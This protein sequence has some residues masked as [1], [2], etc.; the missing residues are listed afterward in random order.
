[1]PTQSSAAYPSYKTAAANGTT[2]AVYSNYPAGAASAH[3]PYGVPPVSHMPRAGTIGPPS[4]PS[5]Y[6]TSPATAAGVPSRRPD[7]YS[8]PSVPPSMHYVPHQPQTMPY[9]WVN[10]RFESNWI[11]FST[12]VIFYRS[13]LMFDLYH[14]FCFHV[15]FNVSTTKKKKLNYRNIGVHV[16]FQCVQCIIFMS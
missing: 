11:F 13:F 14:F 10:I 12:F 8:A 2:S 7:Y 6:G 9:R 16:P 3:T 4:V 5:L 1:M 15:S